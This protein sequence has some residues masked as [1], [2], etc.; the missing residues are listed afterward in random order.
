M[1]S[2]LQGLLNLPS[3]TSPIH[4]REKKK[5]EVNKSGDTGDSIRIITSRSNEQV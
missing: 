4:F 2:L 5:S 3:C 1:V